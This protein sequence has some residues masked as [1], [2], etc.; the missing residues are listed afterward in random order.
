MYGT[1][2]NNSH[3]LSLLRQGLIHIDPFRKQNL[4]LAH[5]PLTVFAIRLR[6]PDGK[7]RRRKEF[8]DDKDPFILKA[9]QYVVVEPAEKVVVEEGI[10]AKFIPSSNIIEQGLALTAGRLEFPFGKAAERLRFGLKNQLDIPI[11]VTAYQQVAYVEFYDLRGLK[12]R[13][14]ELTPRDKEVFSERVASERKHRADDDGVYY[15]DYSDD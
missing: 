11:E 2:A 4:K 3:I 13:P 5:Y 10:I 7:W 9:H 1:L 12:R 15:P 6:E 8:D 14:T